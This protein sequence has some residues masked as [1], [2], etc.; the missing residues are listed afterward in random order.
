MAQA[1][2]CPSSCRREGGDQGENDEIRP[3]DPLSQQSCYFFI[4][5]LGAGLGA[6]LAWYV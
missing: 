5:G 1:I 2:L 4:T 3:G 6:G